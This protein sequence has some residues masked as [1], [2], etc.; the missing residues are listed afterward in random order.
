MHF[1][2]GAGLVICTTSP[3]PVVIACRIW[4]YPTLGRVELV[5]HVR[6]TM[7]PP[8]KGHFGDNINSAD[9]FFAGR[10]SFLGGLECIVGII[11]GP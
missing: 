2:F 8:I 1:A 11:L 6:N 7:E 9:L 5:L 10:F 3:V 4:G